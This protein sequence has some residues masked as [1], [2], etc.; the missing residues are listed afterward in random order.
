MR[1]LLVVLSDIEMLHPKRAASKPKYCYPC[2]FRFK[3]SLLV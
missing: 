2:T 3:R 1:Q